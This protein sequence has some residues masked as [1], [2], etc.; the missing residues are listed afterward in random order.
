[1]RLCD[2]TPNALDTKS[3]LRKEIRLKM[4][5]ESCKSQIAVLEMT[6]FSSAFIPCFAFH[7]IVTFTALLQRKKTL[8]RP[9]LR[10]GPRWVS[11]QRSP[12]PLAGGEGAGCPSTKP[13]PRSRPFGPRFS[14][15]D[16][17]MKN[18][19]RDA[20]TARALAVVR[21]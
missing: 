4:A 17:R 16:S 3:V 19:L 21:F 12:K 18:T 14:C 2:H 15:P 1:V 5:H 11:L 8:R 9:R 10:P 20:N 13:H 7:T 6:S